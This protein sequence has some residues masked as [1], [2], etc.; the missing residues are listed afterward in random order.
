MDHVVPI[1]V[2]Q[3]RSPQKHAGLTGAV[4]GDNA[5][6]NYMTQYSLQELRNSQIQNGGLRPVINWLEAEPP[7]QN[8][9]QLQGITTRVL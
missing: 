2:R 9:F 1:L 6:T 7:T 5:D 4:G 3:M 8:D